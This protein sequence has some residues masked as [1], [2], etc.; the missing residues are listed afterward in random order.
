MSSVDPL[1]LSDVTAALGLL[2]GGHVAIVGGGG[3]S[4][5]LH[6]I[7]R[8]MDGATILTSTTKMGTDQSHGL[9]V[10]LAPTDS[11]LQDALGRSSPVMVWSDT[12]DTKALGV[13]PQD[14]DRWFSTLGNVVIE[15]D[16]ARRRPFKAPRAY[17]PVVPDSVTAM[18][19]VIGLDAVG[20]LIS[21]RCHRPDQ[22]AALAE[23]SPDDFLT[24]ARAAAVLLH[25]D[26]ARRE[27]PTKAGFSVAITKIRPTAKDQELAGELMTEL[28]SRA[29]SVVVVPVEFDESVAG[30]H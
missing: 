21:D 4:T 16:G 20:Q 22:V 5:L 1:A 29:P 26:G 3:K 10:L 17:E 7:G 18:V 11:E 14:C 27:L 12:D 24:P 28:G 25:P 15:A 8:A 30:G 23:C 2:D 13:A 9:P 6:T 19:S